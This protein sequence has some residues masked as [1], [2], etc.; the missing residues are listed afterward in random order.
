MTKATT[1]SL[2]CHG[3]LACS[4]ASSFTSSGCG[5]NGVGSARG[6][7]TGTSVGPSPGLATTRPQ[8]GQVPSGFIDDGFQYFE[9]WSHQ[10]MTVLRQVG[11]RGAW[12][13]SP[14]HGG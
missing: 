10:G 7:L 2:K 1:S 3:A 6:S 4:P 13:P 11:R 9:Q 5:S 14:G 12:P 8:V